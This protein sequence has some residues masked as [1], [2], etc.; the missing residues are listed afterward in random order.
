[1]REEVNMTGSESHE[2][3]HNQS[4]KFVN[5]QVKEA[6]VFLRERFLRFVTGIVG[7]NVT[8]NLYENSKVSGEFRGCD[9][10]CLDIYLQNLQTPL[11]QIPGAIIRSSDIISIEVDNINNINR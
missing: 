11:G 2:P 8:F 3:L 7:E 4:P 10:D 5:P 9:V 1:M 6:R